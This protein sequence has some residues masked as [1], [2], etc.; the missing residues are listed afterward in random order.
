MIDF[1]R[2]RWLIGKLQRVQWDVERKMANATRITSV[3]TGMP[4]GGGGN[5]QEEANVILADV[6][7]AYQDAA[8]ELESMRTELKPLVDALPDPDEKAIMI[9]RYF[10]GYSPED[11][12]E[13]VKLSRAT[14]YAHLNRAERKI[15]YG[16]NA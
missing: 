12:P 16:Q 6:L 1:R 13:M 7:D 4:R 3:I 15:M 14:V 10:D 9:L 11:I 2:M 5:R 8:A